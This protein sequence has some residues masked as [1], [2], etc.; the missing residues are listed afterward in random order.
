MSNS[1]K[2]MYAFLPINVAAIVCIFTGLMY[3]YKNKARKKKKEINHTPTAIAEQSPKPAIK[4][5][6]Y[7]EPVVPDSVLV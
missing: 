1:T 6:I 5:N 7:K 3:Y 4:E 2:A